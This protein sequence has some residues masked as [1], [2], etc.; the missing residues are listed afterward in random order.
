MAF[1]FDFLDLPIRPL[2]IVGVPSLQHPNFFPSPSRKSTSTLW[3]LEQSLESQYGPYPPSSYPC[4]RSLLLRWQW[5]RD[6]GVNRCRYI[7][8]SLT[9]RFFFIE[10][11]YS[12]LFS[13]KVALSRYPDIE[14]QIFE[15]AEKLAEI[16]AGIGLFGRKYGSVVDNNSVAE[17]TRLGAWEVIKKL[18]LE[19]DL[20]ALT[21]LRP[22][23]EP[24]IA[25]SVA[26]FVR[27]FWLIYAV[28]SSILQIQEERWPGGHR[29][30]HSRHQGWIWPWMIL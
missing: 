1:G 28:L 16:G 10:S 19:E 23:Q 17:H 30:L 18:G 26:L 7:D 24:G 15:A 13:L 25:T 3:P 12:F 4:C 29:I 9:A 6:R 22:S 21:D 8:I 20:L 27:T 11:L 2:V 5:S 14:V